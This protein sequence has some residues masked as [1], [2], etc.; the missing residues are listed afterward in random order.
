M[1]MK[2]LPMLAVMTL[3][4]LLMVS[5][6]QKSASGEETLETV[7]TEIEE[8]VTETTEGIQDEIKEMKQ[9]LPTVNIKSNETVS[10]PL[11][12]QLN[13]QGLWMGYEGEVGW[14][15]LVDEAGNELASGILK[16]EGEWMKS[17]PVMYGT[18]LEFDATGHSSGRLIFQQNAGPGEGDEAGPSESFEVAVKF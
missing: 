3:S 4:F 1:K 8:V 18:N 10:S 7:E 11:Y 16:A 14:V 13:S 2:L 12:V 9:S 17:G 5:C 6:K 15:K